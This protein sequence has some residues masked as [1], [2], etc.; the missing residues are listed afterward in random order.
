MVVSDLDGTLLQKDRTFSRTD[1][2]TLQRL[3]AE[4]V[5]RVIA[6]GRS[7]YS[8]RSIVPDD[9]PI[10][11]LIISSGAGIVNW[12]TKAIVCMYSL[13]PAEV[14]GA[15]S[16]LMESGA[17]FMIH[18]PI[19]NNHFF[20]YH[21]SGK[22]NPDF[23]SRIELYRDFVKTP[24]PDDPVYG[25]ACQILAVEPWSE[26]GTRY[27][28]YAKKLTPLNV[29][30][31]TSPI[32]HRSTWIEIFPAQV[33]KARAS[34]T[35]GRMHGIDCTCVL[36]VGNDYNDIELLSWARKGVVVENAPGDMK[37]AFDTVRSND[38]AGFTEAVELYGPFKGQGRSS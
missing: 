4:G 27:G 19:P 11:Y 8:A 25:E 34:D 37:S 24:R 7:L 22:H 36:A 28:F 6:T 1:I 38:E 23:Y 30:R 13:F 26:N 2:K 32:D 10:D 15:A 31:T 20:F 5:L 17:D 3:G 12:E 18:E 35:I 14:K 9:F 21:S 33:S 16:V 29:I